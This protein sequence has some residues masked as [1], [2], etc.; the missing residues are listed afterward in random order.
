MAETKRIKLSEPVEL[1]GRKLSEV[2]LK[3][4]TG[5]MAA[6]LGEPR[7]MVFSGATGGY[8]VERE[9]VV[10]KYLEKCIDAEGGADLL[11]LVSLI[12]LLKIKGALFDFFTEAEAAIAS[13]KLQSFAS[14]LNASHLAKPAD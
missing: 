10:A 9:D 11:K 5:W 7:V 14:A 12:D 1:F 3:E 8:Y 6:T 4:P 2:I 13:E